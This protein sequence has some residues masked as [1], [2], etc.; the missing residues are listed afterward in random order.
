[1]TRRRT[2]STVVSMTLLVAAHDHCLRITT[3]RPAVSTHR[4]E[5]H[6]TQTNKPCRR[7]VALAARLR[8][9]TRR[10]HQEVGK[11]LVEDLPP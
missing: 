1:M 5:Y 7:C 10:F 8:P 3:R 11:C 2:R 9:S 6:V 4:I